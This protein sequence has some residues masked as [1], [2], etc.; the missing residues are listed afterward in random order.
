[1]K[2]CGKKTSNEN[3]RSLYSITHCQ[4]SYGQP[5]RNNILIEYSDLDTEILDCDKTV[6]LMYYGH[7]I[8]IQNRASHLNISELVGSKVSKETKL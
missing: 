7:L 1:M 3:H 2:G 6:T 8:K 5:T 4:E